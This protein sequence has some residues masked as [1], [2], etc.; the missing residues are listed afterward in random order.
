MQST[1]EINLLSVRSNEI[2]CA[3]CSKSS[4][5]KPAT[6]TFVID[7]VLSKTSAPFKDHDIF[8]GNKVTVSCHK[9]CTL[10]Q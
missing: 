7:F 9:N 6:G 10:S 8:L 3:E 2:Q 1:S 5:V 4:S